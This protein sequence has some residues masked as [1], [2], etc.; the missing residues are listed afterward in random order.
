M[1]YTLRFA[2]PLRNFL[3]WRSHNQ[4]STNLDLRVVAGAV[5]VC[6]RVIVLRVGVGPVVVGTHVVTD[7]MSVREVHET[8]DMHH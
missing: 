4:P 7:L 2:L 3:L 8:V 6:V 5:P 1:S